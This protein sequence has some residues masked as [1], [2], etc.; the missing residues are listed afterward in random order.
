[1]RL[2]IYC[3]E[4]DQIALCQL[5]RLFRTESYLCVNRLLVYIIRSRTGALALYKQNFPWLCSET[6]KAGY[7][8]QSSRLLGRNPLAFFFTELAKAY[9]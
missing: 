2:A 8:S 3:S 5:Q 6:H 9:Y 7:F 4:T 1:M